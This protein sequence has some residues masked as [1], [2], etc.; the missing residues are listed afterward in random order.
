V[1]HNTKALRVLDM[2][3]ARGAGLLPRACMV[4][5]FAMLLKYLTLLLATPELKPVLVSIR[6]LS[7]VAAPLVYH[8][9]TV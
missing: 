9:S 4:K 2:Q 5:L 6:H 8:Y 1:A 3:L 7:G